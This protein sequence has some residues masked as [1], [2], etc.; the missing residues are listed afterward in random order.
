MFA[1]AA[2]VFLGAFLLFQVQ[3]IVAKSI[4]PWFGGAPAVWTT[5]MLC[6]QTLLLLGYAYAHASVRLLRPR[7]QG[8]VHLVLL[9]AALLALPIHA[10][11]ALRSGGAG[12]P[13]FEILLLLLRCVALPYFVLAA[14]AP[15]VQAWSARTS[16]GSSPYRL[17]ALSNAGSM[18]GLLAYPVAI[19]PWMA[20]RTQ[21]YVWSWAFV[22]FAL[23]SLLCVRNAWRAAPLAIEATKNAC[24]PAEVSPR[25]TRTQRLLWLALPACATT[26]LLAV[27][28]QLCQEVA[29]IPLLWILPLSVYLLSFVLCFESERWY[30]RSWCLPVLILTL[31]VL[32]QCAALGARVGILFAVPVYSLGLFVCCMF[33]HGELAARRPGPERLTAYYLMIALGGALGGAFVS[34]AAPLVF[35]GFDEMYVGLL[36]CALLAAGFV[37]KSPPLRK[38]GRAWHPALPVL[39]AMACIIAAVLSM[40]VM[41]R[42]QPGV[43]E[44]RNFYGILK[45]HDLTAPDGKGD[46]RY[47]THGGTRHGQQFTAPERRATPTTY[48]GRASGAGILLEEL[49]AQPKLHVG[50]IGLGAGVLAAYGRPGDTYRYYEINPLVIDIAQ[51]EFTFLADSRAASEIVRGDARLMLEREADQGFDVLLVDAF[52]S[53]AIPVHLLTEEA[54]ALYFRHIAADGVLALHVSTRHLDLGPLIVA[55]AEGAQKSTLEI[56]S[57]A[58]DEHATL[59]A[60]W[61]LVSS[62]TELLTSE[63]VRAAGMPVAVS[64]TPLRVWTDDF[65]NLLHVLK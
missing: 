49:A 48:Y 47:L 29:V 12:A 5:C 8:V 28:N 20:T 50:I 27:T 10:N 62:N 33:C 11:A 45:V 46:M 36:A 42:T 23:L 64:A 53:D 38:T 18:L 44:L 40:R 56:H 30:S 39:I 41:T 32:T 4:L 26:L 52:S 37:F 31:I 60:R 21:G 3:P 6:F 14:S 16:A 34:I 17:Y 22:A 7:T 57:A 35:R 15:L 54:F 65:S 24:V 51:R 55:L 61:I 59:D 19:E 43:R 2:T 9:V 13:T 58:S 63:R 1:H 25:P